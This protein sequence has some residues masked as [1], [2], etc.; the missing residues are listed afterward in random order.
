MV[1]LMDELVFGVYRQWKKNNSII[2]AYFNCTV[3]GH[4]T[5]FTLWPFLVR[6]TCR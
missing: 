6:N 3:A 2:F 1:M 5:F 4:Q